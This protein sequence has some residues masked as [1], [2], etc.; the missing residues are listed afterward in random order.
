MTILITWSGAIYGTPTTNWTRAVTTCLGSRSLK[1]ISIQ[2]IPV[3]IPILKAHEVARQTGNIAI[4]TGGNVK[5][6]VDG[7]LE[8]VTRI[9]P[10]ELD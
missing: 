10:S 7:E 6:D 5:I 1:L 3:E 2:P 9:D 4:I 8:G